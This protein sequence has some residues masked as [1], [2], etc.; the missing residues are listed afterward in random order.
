MFLSKILYKIL[1][2]KKFSK[3]R[4]NYYSYRKIFYKP[5]S[6]SQ[7]RNI[8]VNKIGLHKGSVVFIHSSMDFLNTDVPAERILEI[9]LETVGS[10]GTLIFPCWQFKYRAEDYLKKDKIF[11]VENS[12][13]V[14]GVL[15]EIARQWPGALRSI[16][17]IN[18]ILA[19]GKHAGELIREHHKSVYP[20]GE[21]SP[22]YKMMNYDAVI[23]GLGVS[24]HFLSFIHCPEDIMK[25]KFP[26]KTR[27]DEIFEGKVRLKT[28]EIINVPTLVAHSNIVNRDLPKFVRK[29]LDKKTFKQFRIKG[30]DFF[31]ADSKKLFDRVVELAEKGIS[32]YDC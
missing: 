15:P 23:I 20:C 9:L 24:S 8:M 29:Y 28:T 30:S 1:P 5:L 31:W 4:F 26:V 14:M 17:P 22:Y 25:D 32:I 18:S 10:E 19:I 7:I 2:V 21:L 13:T 27:T 6:E 16:H 11:D 3:I 12:R